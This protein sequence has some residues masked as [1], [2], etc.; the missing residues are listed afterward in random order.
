MDTRWVTGVLGEFAD[1][2]REA[3]RKVDELVRWG[4]EEFVL[5]MPRAD[6]VSASAVAERIR[7]HIAETPFEV[8]G[9][10]IEQTVSIGV[11]TWDGAESPSDLERRA[12][13]AMY[14]AKRAGRNRVH[15]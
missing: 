3:T 8:D 4:G 10:R 5:V 9:S 11:A 1:R 12:D 14:R 13:E 7:A 6:L 2:V 15:L